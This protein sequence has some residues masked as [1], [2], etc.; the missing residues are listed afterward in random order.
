L[1][2]FRRTSL[3]AAL[4][5]V[6]REAEALGTGIVGSEIV[7]LVPEAAVLGALREALALE[8]FDGDLVLER[9]LEKALGK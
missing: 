3:A 5:R 1:L 9:R 6:R 4:A 8:R 7:G 2:D